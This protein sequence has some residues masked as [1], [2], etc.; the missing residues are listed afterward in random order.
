M[1]VWRAERTVQLAGTKK[2]EAPIQDTRVITCYVL[3][4]FKTQKQFPETHIPGTIYNT[5]IILSYIFVNP[6]LS[7]NVRIVFFYSSILTILTSI[8]KS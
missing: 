2:H 4:S 1:E 6:I 5:I 8:V 3:W 7:K